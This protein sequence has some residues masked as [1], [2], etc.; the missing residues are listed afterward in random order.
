MNDLVK[1]L[2]ENFETKE[3]DLEQFLGIEVDQRIDGSIFIHQASYCKRILSKFNMESAN[4][5]H[6]PTDP[7]HT[8]DSNMSKS[9]SSPAEGV[10]YREAVGSLLYLSQITRPDITFAVNL[11]SR[12]LENPQKIHWNAV[13]RIFKY[14]KSTSNYGILYSND[15]NIKIIC[16][17]DAHYDGDL[18]QVLRFVLIKE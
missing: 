9:E 11:V 1:C 14:L 10:P 5:V 7:Q 17:S 13:K 18:H 8:L 15:V 6:I 4:I 16:Y 3:G 2:K 12:Y